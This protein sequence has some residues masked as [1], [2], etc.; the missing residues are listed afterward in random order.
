MLVGESGCDLCARIECDTGLS[1]GDAVVAVAESGSTC[2][3][4]RSCGTVVS[5]DVVVGVVDGE[6]VGEV[7]DGQAMGGSRDPPLT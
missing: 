7:V 1:P 5:L 2:R 6:D 4:R 3:A